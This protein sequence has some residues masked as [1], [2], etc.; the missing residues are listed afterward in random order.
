MTPPDSLPPS[1][2]PTPSSPR[3]SVERR[4][5]AGWVLLFIQLALLGYATLLVVRTILGLRSEP[6]GALTPPLSAVE[7]LSGADTAGYAR[8]MAPIPFQFPEDHG[9]HPEYRTEW[10]YLTGNLDG[11]DGRPYGYQFTLFRNA[12]SPLSPDRGSLWDTNQLWLGHLA[13]TDPTGGRHLQAERFARG[14]AGLAG[15]SGAPFRIWVDGWSLGTEGASGGGGEGADGE[16][17]FPL[18]VQAA[19]E[20]WG[21][22]LLL[23]PEKGLVLQGREGWSPKGP[24]AGNASYYYSYT[25]LAA[26][27]ELTLDGVA[28]PVAGGSWMDREWST[29]ALGEGLE[30]WDWFSLQL[31]DGSELMLFQLRR[32]E[33]TRDPLDQGLWVSRSGEATPLTAAEFELE[34][35]DQWSSPLDGTTYPAGWR[36]TIPHLSLTLDVRP[37]LADQE[38]RLTFRYWEGAVRASGV[39]AGEIVQGRG[40]VE[41]TG[42]A[43]GGIDGPHRR[44]R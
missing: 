13:L 25:R 17:I 30:G 39:R 18:R 15:G 3:P 36:L 38:M 41:L 12:L 1:T 11:M 27:G 19:A 4:T 33:G 22:D 35:L 7:I 44:H 28:V 31:E 43:G 6:S 9:P 24:E 32:S 40:Y 26:T 34:V 37:L 14:S 21:V 2:P 42:Y 16:D 29:S 10:W 5:P 8:A 20:G 23:R